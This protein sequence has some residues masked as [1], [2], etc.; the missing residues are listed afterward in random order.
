MVSDDQNACE[1]EIPELNLAQKILR[2]FQRHTT[3]SSMKI[4]LSRAH[5]SL[6]TYNNSVCVFSTCGLSTSIVV[7]EDILTKPT[8]TVSR[9]WT[10]CENS[11]NKLILQNPREAAYLKKSKSGV[12]ICAEGKLLS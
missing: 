12:K 3:F 5:G 9:E 7:S 8:L 1:R 11:G 2:N 10:G 6:I 4:H